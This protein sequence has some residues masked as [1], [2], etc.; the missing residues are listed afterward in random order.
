MHDFIFMRRNV[1]VFMHIHK[2]FGCVLNVGPDYS[3]E[4]V[5]MSLLT[6]GSELINGS[7][8]ILLHTNHVW[9]LISNTAAAAA[10][11]TATAAAAAAKVSSALP[12][13]V[14][15]AHGTPPR[16]TFRA[17]KTTRPRCGCSTT[18]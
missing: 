4:F 7:W 3:L 15:D 14:F 16:W 12:A 10:T 13:L 6:P 11:A 8:G 9:N 18:R 5:N 17:S 1:G 2:Y